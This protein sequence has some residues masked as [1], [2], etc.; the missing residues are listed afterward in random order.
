[1]YRSRR[2]RS[3]GGIVIGGLQRSLC[4]L[5]LAGFSVL[6][7]ALETIAHPLAHVWFV[8]QLHLSGN[9]G[10]RKRTKA[11]SLLAQ[12]VA[13]WDRYDACNTRTPKALTSIFPVCVSPVNRSVK[14]F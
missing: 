3:L 4:G 14:V 7:G 2:G 13:T 5:A 6:F 11:A 9:R 1:M 8:T 12:A 10:R